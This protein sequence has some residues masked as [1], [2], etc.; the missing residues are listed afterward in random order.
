[1]RI[2]GWLSQ[3]ILPMLF[4]ILLMLAFDTPSLTVMT[5]CAA[6]IHELGHIFA[7]ALLGIEGVSLPS[8]V[9][10][11]LRIRT[12]R[13]LSYREELILAAGGP[14]WSLGAFLVLLPFST[15]SGYLFLFSLVNLMT[16][17]SNLVPLR[18]NDGYRIASAALCGA[19]S[20][21]RA[22]R[23][24]SVLSVTAAAL[25]VLFSLAFLM[26]YGEGYWF[27][28]VFFSVMIKELFRSG[29]RTKNE[30]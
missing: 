18:G 9:L 29:N 17:I 28:A 25:G 14:L 21:E 5:L 27:F 19:C 20:L 24:C 23:I 26:L 4:W 10:T 7:A 15:A 2:L 1:M 11:G 3:K 16:A 8:A 22:E 12:P 13:L 6:A 30:N